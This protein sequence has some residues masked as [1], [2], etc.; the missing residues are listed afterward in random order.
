[1]VNDGSTDDTRTYL[2]SLDG[3]EWQTIR[4]MNLLPWDDTIEFPIV[5]KKLFPNGETWKIPSWADPKDFEAFI[6][7]WSKRCLLELRG[8]QEEFKDPMRERMIFTVRIFL[9]DK[10]FWEKWRE[11]FEC[12]VRHFFA[13]TV[14]MTPVDYGDIAQWSESRMLGWNQK[15]LVEATNILAKLRGQLRCLR[16]EKYS[17]DEFK[18]GP[19][20]CVVPTE[21]RL[22]CL[23]SWRNFTN[24]KLSW[25]QCLTDIWR[26]ACLDQVR[27]GRH[28]GLYRTN[29]MKESDSSTMFADRNRLEKTNIGHTTS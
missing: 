10:Q 16:F 17:M 18:I 24:T 3:E 9:E 15:E 14:R 29:M 27:E 12:M 4:S 11:E 1:V 6:T 8:W 19:T 20:H 23:R 28:A 13:D 7:L 2:D 22:D 21:Y 26:L 5:E 25:R